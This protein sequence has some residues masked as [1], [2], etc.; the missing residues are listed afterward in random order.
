MQIFQNIG[1]HEIFLNLFLEA[2]ITMILSAAGVHQ[3]TPLIIDFG[4]KN[5][6]QDCKIGI[7]CWGGYL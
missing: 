1:E 6:R 5:E 7:V 4:I 3:E 2:S